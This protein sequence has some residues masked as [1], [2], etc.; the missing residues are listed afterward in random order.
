LGDLCVGT[1]SSCCPRC[2]APSTRQH[3]RYFRHLQDLP[4][5]GTAVVVKMQVS[6]WRCL[7]GECERET[8]TDQ[9][10]EIV[11]PH[12]RRTKRIAELV[13]LFGDGTGGRPGEVLMK[14]LGV[15]VS[16]DTILRHLKCRSP[17]SARGR[18]YGWQASTI[19]AGE[20]V[21]LTGLLSLTSSGARSSNVLQNRS[22][23]LRRN[24]IGTDRTRRHTLLQPPPLLKME[25][26][27]RL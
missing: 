8:F 11:C 20:R 14:R 23:R 26:C 4:V 18:L 17:V 19:G 7:N 5:Q 24:M 9:L 22:P 2:R 3:S 10:P 27:L 25:G 6:R 15:P 21:A 12:V 16:D 13:H 1:G